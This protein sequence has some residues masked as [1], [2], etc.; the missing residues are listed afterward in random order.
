MTTAKMNLIT[1]LV[2]G[3]LSLAVMEPLQHPWAA[4]A[5][6]DDPEFQ[7]AF[8]EID[9]LRRMVEAGNLTGFRTYARFTVPDSF[10]NATALKKVTFADGVLVNYNIL[11]K[12]LLDDGIICDD[13]N[14]TALINATIV[15]IGNQSF[16]EDSQSAIDTEITRS[17]GERRLD[18]LKPDFDGLEWDGNFVDVF[19]GLDGACN[20]CPEDTVRTRLEFP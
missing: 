6:R 11:A 8:E 17:G 15:R 9:E 13:G 7:G 1:K 20:D 2:L 12:E 4:Q 14:F 10:V 19:L 5:I 18:F 3:F 16:F